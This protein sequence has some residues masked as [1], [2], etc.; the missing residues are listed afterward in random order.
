VATAFK[1]GFLYFAIVF[2][3]GF[4]LGTIRVVALVPSFGETIAVAIESPIVLAASWLVCRSLLARFAVSAQ[5]SSRIAMGASA[6]AFLMLSEAILAT[7][8]FG[9]SLAEHLAHYR[10]TPGLLGLAGQIAFALFP[11]IQ[12]AWEPSDAPPN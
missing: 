6:F 4:L 1:A 10:S 11:A 9:R 5:V 8:G 12:L 3:L 2:A 7:F